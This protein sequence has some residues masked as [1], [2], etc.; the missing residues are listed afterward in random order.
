MLTKKLP[1]REWTRLDNAAGI[2]TKGLVKFS[3]AS[4]T[5]SPEFC[6]PTS[7]EIVLAIFK[8]LNA[9]NLLKK[10]NNKPEKVE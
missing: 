3:R 5:P 8:F 9:I 2:A 10:T 1:K 6:I 4:T 7:I